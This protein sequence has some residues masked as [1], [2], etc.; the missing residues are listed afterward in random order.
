MATIILPYTKYGGVQ[1]SIP[2]IHTLIVI[3]RD[4]CG[5][6]LH[7][8]AVDVNLLLKQLAGILEEYNEITDDESIE[9]FAQHDAEGANEYIHREF[10]QCFDNLDW[11]VEIESSMVILS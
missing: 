1:T 11:R 6:K 4:T 3:G 7:V 9:P 5:I 2:G 8:A 10:G